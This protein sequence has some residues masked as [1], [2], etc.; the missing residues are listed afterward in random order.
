MSWDPFERQ[1]RLPLFYRGRTLKLEYIADLVCY[2]KI[3]IE[4]K[5]VPELASRHRSQL[6]NYLSA[7]GFPLG[8][9]LNFGH[10]P[11][12]EHERLANTRPR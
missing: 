9:L 6:L 4:V 5:A 10:Y 3:I 11:R 7:T 12:L 1:V 8:M 2:G